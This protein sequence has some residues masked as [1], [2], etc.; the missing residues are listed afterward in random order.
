MFGEGR[1]RR[2]GGPMG[3]GGFGPPPW[4]RMLHR[5]GGG[6]SF[7]RG[8]NLN[9]EQLEH[10]AELKLAT[11]RQHMQMR[12]SMSSMM[13]DLV[14]ELSNDHIDKAKVKEIGKQIQAQKTQAGDEFLDRVIAFAEIL[15]P[16]QRKTMRMRAIKSF[17]GVDA[18]PG[19]PCD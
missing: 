14:K 2:G 12:L 8:L 16:E 5:F 10:I 13:K 9:D 7:L 6:G 4:A 19:E 1:G 17:L 15:T 11:M 18:P 3:F